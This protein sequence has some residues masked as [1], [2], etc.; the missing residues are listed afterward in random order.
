[1]SRWPWQGAIN[2]IFTYS[3]KEKVAIQCTQVEAHA[4]SYI[5]GGN[6]LQM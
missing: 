6:A 3:A 1:M 2:L 5:A 4:Y